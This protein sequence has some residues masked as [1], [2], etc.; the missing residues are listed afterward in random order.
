M[1]VSESFEDIVIFEPNVYVQFGLP[2]C[3]HGD[4]EIW[5]AAYIDI[6]PL[7]YIFHNSVHHL[8]NKKWWQ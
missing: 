5:K 3:I 1:G 2:R 6:D 7:Y 4:D 8:A